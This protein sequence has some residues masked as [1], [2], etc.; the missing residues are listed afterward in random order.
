MTL[1]PAS[2]TAPSVDR[3]TILTFAVIVTDEKG[4]QDSDGVKVSVNNMESVP[5]LGT[6]NSNN[7]LDNTTA[8]ALSNAQLSDR[9][10]NGNLRNN[11]NRTGAQTITPQNTQLSRMS[12]ITPQALSTGVGIVQSNNL[13]NTR[14]AY[15]IIFRT[16]SAGTIGR[17]EVTFPSGTG[18]GA[19]IPLK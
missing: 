14:T 5:K 1:V 9:N 12:V 4:A 16:A 11:N 2:F 18:I 10:N 8:N 19:A 17:F 7:P 6:T 15:D 3:D 13:V